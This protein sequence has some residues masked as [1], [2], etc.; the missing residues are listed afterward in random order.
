MWSVCPRCGVEIEGE[1]QDGEDIWFECD[2][3]GKTWVDNNL[4]E[5]F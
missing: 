3:C 5:S 4:E 2:V 1:V